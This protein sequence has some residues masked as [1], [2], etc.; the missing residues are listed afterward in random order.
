MKRCRRKRWKSADSTHI[1]IQ[2]A[3]ELQCCTEDI[4]VVPQDISVKATHRAYLSFILISRGI[5][6]TDSPGQITC[7][8]R[9]F[10]FPACPGY[11]SVFFEGCAGDKDYFILSKY[12]VW[13]RVWQPLLFYTM[14]T[15]ISVDITDHQV[16]C[17]VYYMFG[18]AMVFIDLS[19]AYT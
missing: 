17:L 12:A 13:H 6:I 15:R 5:W 9:L 8:G 16:M 2:F 10:I 14:L 11:V 7:S 19:I 18:G 1:F 3:S 4:S